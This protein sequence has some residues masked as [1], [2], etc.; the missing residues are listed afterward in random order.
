MLGYV[1]AKRYVPAM[2]APK[3]KPAKAAP[4]RKSESKVPRKSPRA[5]AKKAYHH[6]D[7]RRALLDASIAL[8]A[9]SGVEALSLREVAQRIGVSSAA[10]YHHFG[11]K[12]QLLGAIAASGFVGLGD[13]M[14]T[15]IAA[16][17]DPEEPLLRLEA[18]GNAYVAFAVRHPTEFRLM[19]RP[20]M[21]SAKDLPADCD[22]SRGFT[23]LLDAV[24]R[25][26]RALSPGLIPP[27]GLVL[28]A[29]SVVH[30]AAELLLEGPLG[31]IDHPLRVHE[32]DVGPLV[33]RTLTTL[34]R[35]ASRPSA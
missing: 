25:V 33:V 32:R 13:A 17:K 29:W 2:P 9:E 20:S 4:Q 34:L 15:A 22:P 11:S 16:L 8:I 18:I 28:T 10:P 12:A 5:E 7:L 31:Q 3:K 26:T 21:V 6:G 1:P 24:G 35:S 23:Q 14:E 19:F 30:G 27:E